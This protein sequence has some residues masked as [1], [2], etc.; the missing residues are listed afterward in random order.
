VHD[1]RRGVHHAGSVRRRHEHRDVHVRRERQLELSVARMPRRP[2]SRLRHERHAVHDG[3]DDLQRSVDVR[4]RGVVHVFRRT[5]P[6]PA[7]GLCRRR[8]V[9]SSLRPK[10]RRRPRR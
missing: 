10:A 8:S 5:L 7:R 3:R 6:L 1:A 2:V 4:W 9:I